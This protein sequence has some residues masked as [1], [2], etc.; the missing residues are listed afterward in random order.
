MAE[1]AA[2]GVDVTADMIAPQYLQRVMSVQRAIESA[3]FTSAS[4][5]QTSSFD[6]LCFKPIEGEGCLVE[7]PSQYW[8]HDPVLLAED[9]SPSL[10][11]ACQTTQTFLASRSPCMDEVRGCK[12]GRTRGFGWWDCKSRRRSAA[13]RDSGGLMIVSHIQY[14][15]TLKYSVV[16]DRGGFVA[17]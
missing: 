11:A 8:L 14:K 16:K 1:S 7:S 12:S 5:G 9:D 3:T 4:D 10:T 6:A 17:A 13:S 15:C 2:D